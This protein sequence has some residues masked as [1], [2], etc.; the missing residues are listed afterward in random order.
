MHESDFDR[1]VIDKSGRQI[2]LILDETELV[3]CAKYGDTQ[4]GEMRFLLIDEEDDQQTLKLVWMYLDRAGKSY[5]HSGIGRHMLQLM[6][7]FN[8]GPVFA[9]SV[10]GE[11]QDDGS[12]LTGDAPGF[13]TKMR[14]EGLIA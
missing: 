2:D 4:I 3:L 1:T 5:I 10:G 12:H 11:K 13:V 8:G 9:E 7:E 14:E 6:N